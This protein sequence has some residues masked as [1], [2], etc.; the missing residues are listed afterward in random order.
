MNGSYVSETGH[1]DRLHEERL[2]SIERIAADVGHAVRSPLQSLFIN[3]EVLRRR[4]QNDARDEALERTTVIENEARRI[5]DLIEAFMIVLRP[6]PAT[7]EVFDLDRA[8]DRIAPLLDVMARERRA[9]F[10]RT[11]ESVLVRAP[12]ET[13]LYAIARTAA[14]ACDRTPP[15]GE[16]RLSVDAGS[17]AVR[18]VVESSAESPDSAHAT[19]PASVAGLVS[20]LARS[21][22]TVA[23][24]AGSP[25][26]DGGHFCFRVA[27]A[28]ARLTEASGLS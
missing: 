24:D 13:L 17:T 26:R 5:A 20:F 14:A 8:I 9:T 16:L 19:A 12:E 7:A 3:L 11:S 23:L 27:R 22:G 25:T 4:V 10:H 28:D 21:D 18:V 6:A 2:L 15:G 1:T